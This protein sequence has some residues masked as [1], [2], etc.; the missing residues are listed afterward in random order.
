MGNSLPSTLP[1]EERALVPGKAPTILASTL[2]G[3]LIAIDK[4]SGTV[5]WSLTDQPAVKSP[6]DPRNPVLPAFL[7]D[8]KVHIL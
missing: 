8:P 4:M 1:S 2:D 3:T 7:P 5:F 6:Y